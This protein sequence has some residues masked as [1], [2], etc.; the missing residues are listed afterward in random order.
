M[1]VELQELRELVAQLRVDNERLRQGQAAAVLGPSDQ[2]SDSSEAFFSRRQQDGETL[3][4]FSL[5]LMSLMAPV[6]ER[7]PYGMANAEDLLRDQFVEHVQDG[8]LRRELMQYV[9]RQPTATLL[10]VRSE[11][12]RWE[13]EGLPGGSRG[14]SQSVPSAFGLQYGVQGSRG[15]TT[16][17]MGSELAV[18]PCPGVGKLVP[19]GLQSHSPAGVNPGSVGVLELMSACPHVNVSMGGVQVPCLVDTGSMVS[20]VTE[21]WFLQNLQPW[22]HD[23]LRS[24]NW[25]KLKAANGLA[26]PYVGYLEL[27]VKICGTFVPRCGVLVVRDH[28]GEVSSEVP[29]ILGMNIIRRCYHV[30]FGQHGQALFNLPS[31][32]EAPRSVTLALQMCSQQPSSRLTGKVKVRGRKACRIPGGT[33]K[34]VVATCS[35]QF[36]G[37]SVL[38]EP[39]ENGL[40]AGLL[41]SPALVRVVRGTAYIPIVNVGTTSVL[42]YPRTIAGTLDEGCIVSMPAGVIEVPTSVATSASQAVSD[43]TPDLVEAID[44]SALPVED[45]GKVQSLLR[46]Y[47]SV[48]SSHEGDLGC[49]SLIS[50]DIPLLDDVPVRQCHRRIPPSEYEV[51]KEHINQL[52]EAQIIRESSSPYGSPIVLVKK[53]DGSLRMCVDYRQLNNKTRKDAFPLPRIEESLDALTGAR[54]F[55]T[56]DLASGYNQVPVTEADRPKTAF[57]TPFGLFEWNRMP[58]GLCNAPSTFQRLMQRLFGDQQCQSLLLYLDDIVVFS[59]TVEQ[60]LERLKVV[61]GRLQEQGLK[62]R[63][64][65]CA[66]FRREVRYLGHLVSNQGV[67]TDPSKIEVVAN[68]PT[69][70]TVTELRSFL[71]LASYYR[72]FVEGFAKLAAPLH[73]LVANLNVRKPKGSEEAVAGNWS[74]ECNQN[75]EALKTKLTTTPVLAYADFTLPFI[76]EVDASHSGLGAVLS[77]EQNGKVRPIAY[78]SRGLRPTE[79]NM[80]N[81]SSMKLEFVAL[82]WAMTEKFREYLLGHKC[83]VFTDNNPLSHLF[84]AKLGA[85]EQR[86]AAQLAAFDFDIKYRSGRNNK[87]ADALSRKHPVGP[88]DL[89]VM[90][91]GTSIPEPLRQALQGQSQSA[92][93]AA[94]AALPHHA[95]ADLQALQQ[96][97]P[98]L[99]E[100]L[101]FWGRKQRPNTQERRL[102]SSSAWAILRQWG[103]LVERDGIL[104]RKIFRPDGKEA[105]LQLLVPSV[106]KHE[107]MAQV[108]QGHGHQG[109]ERTLEILR[110]RCYWPDMSPDPNEIVA[111]DFTLLE[112]SRN[113]LENVLVMTD[114]FSKYT[115]AVPTRDQRA[116]TVAQALVS[117]WFF[118]FGVPARIHSDQ[119]RNF[120]SLLLQQ[121]C[122]LYGVEKSRTTPYHPAGNGQCERFNRTLHNLLRAF[123]ASRKRDWHSCLPQVLYSYNTTPHQSTGESPFYLMFG[124]EPRLPVDFLLGRVENPVEGEIHEWVEEHQTRLQLAFE[125]ARERLRVVAERRKRNHDQHVRDLPLVVGQLVWLRNHGLR[126]RRKIQ[127]LWGPTVYR[128]LRAPQDGGSVYTIAPTDDQTK[129]QRVH[130]T[131]LKA[132]VGEA[133]LGGQLVPS[134]LSSDQSL[135]D[136][137][138]DE[139][140]L[141]VMEPGVGLIEAPSVAPVV[142]PSASSD[143]D[144]GAA[145]G[146]TSVPSLGVDLTGTTA[147]I[148]YLYPWQ[149]HLPV[150]PRNTG[151]EDQIGQQLVGTLTFIISQGQSQILR[152]G[153]KG[154]QPPLNCYRCRL[155]CAF[156]PLPGC[157][158][159][160]RIACIAYG[161]DCHSCVPLRG[162]IV[163][164]PI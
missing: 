48:F 138:A 151:C 112:P 41:A 149:S 143:Q 100:V 17:L 124:R 78:A 72:R 60:H 111:I 43:V 53:K 27:D 58:F 52:L 62:A 79:R 80:A 103:R 42:L 130:R 140:D 5:A 164:G 161:P 69:P 132:V 40:P 12:I 99:Q 66:F 46:Q 127:D 16:P 137:Q 125:G 11:A 51:V 95:P 57:C 4:E 142:V 94:I 92:S 76:L 18:S 15:S 115:L 9:R 3:H 67:S 38:F 54:W 82:K 77:Q 28:L 61:L 19:T 2:P 85:T 90:V 154:P 35:E 39:S 157:C 158:F 119:G 153:Q 91:S 93:Q 1:E 116:T 75:F 118:K 162:I 26:I 109:V 13:R 74:E 7:A 96:A 120:E 123:P 73:Q 113:G 105:V 44:L 144:P 156:L 71:G 122:T 87:N 136:E 139:E 133:P 88:Q 148:R 59:S 98:I 102:I 8:A 37:R 47:A 97:D 126:G 106:L 63:L 145:F 160:L 163:W 6:R 117:E 49:T 107:V 30:L 34:I 159:A 147:T 104:F 121:L 36:S 134:S 31:V 50:H 10:D 150:A 32:T 135:L 21:S 152:S 84:S 129:V 86:W 70:A 45:Q 83:I 24:C 22:G 65:K 81:Y 146:A 25:L 155:S 114:V 141:F 33:M 23:R 20:T 131:L 128:I 29:G 14:R 56:L 64:E 110:E 108:H 101:T 55:S 89:E 68:W